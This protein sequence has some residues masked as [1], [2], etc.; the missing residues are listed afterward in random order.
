[1]ISAL[2]FAPTSG[3]LYTSACRRPCAPEGR[4][5]CSVLALTGVESICLT[6]SLSA[7]GLA[8]VASVSGLADV[9]VRFGQISKRKDLPEGRQAGSLTRLKSKSVPPMSPAFI[10]PK[11]LWSL[12]ELAAYDGSSSEDG[13]ILLG[14]R[15]NVY[16]VAMSR[17]FYGPGGEYHGMA[18]RDAS[19]L[20][21]RSLRSIEEDRNPDAPL[22]LV[23]RAALATWVYSFDSK[24]DVVGALQATEFTADV[25]DPAKLEAELALARELAAA[26]YAGDAAALNQALSSSAD[27]KWSD[28]FGNTALHR[29]AESGS[30]KCVSALLAAGAELN[31]VG[32]RGRTPLHCACEGGHIDAI[33][34]L[35][36]AGASLEITA[37]EQGWTMALAA[38]GATVNAAEA[39]YELYVRGGN[40]LQA[41]TGGVTPLVVA[42]TFGNLDACKVLLDA[43]ADGLAIGPRSKSA[44]EWA[45]EKGHMDVAELLRGTTA[46]KAP[47]EHAT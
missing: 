4:H 7:L 23:E 5:S 47:P 3:L 34:V 9:I 42:A 6:A 46:S 25:E 22:S 2:L 43:G 18:G 24:Y 12:S 11:P 10:T 44:A 31:A 19:R 14:A 27:V 29:A 33:R 39:L 41:S 36:D 26:A 21:A 1:M 8:G 20:L 40:V 32:S 45:E 35:C 38:A 30:G 37:G 16:N 17:Q 13:P 15:G 28:E